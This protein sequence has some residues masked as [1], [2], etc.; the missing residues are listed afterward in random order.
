MTHPKI[1][2][3][4]T[5]LYTQDLTAST[6]FYEEVL[7]LSL[8]LDQGTCRIYNVSSTAQLGICQRADVQ[9]DHSDVIFTIVTEDVDGW[10]RYLLEKGVVFEKVPEINPT[11]NIYHCFLRDPD[12]YLLEIQHFLNPPEG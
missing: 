6:I 7:G 5:F 2:Q 1:D 10:Y 4:M 8:W 12:G 11:Y 3:Q 9:R